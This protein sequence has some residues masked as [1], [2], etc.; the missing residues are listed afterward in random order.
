[1]TDT[2]W[3]WLGKVL[4]VNSNILRSLIYHRTTSYC[5]VEEG[6]VALASLSSP[7]SEEAL[8]F[9]FFLARFFALLDISLLPSDALRC[10]GGDPFPFFFVL[11]TS[12]HS[13]SSPLSESDS[14]FNAANL[15]VENV[16][17]L[18]MPALQVNLSVLC[19]IYT[20]IPCHVV[21]SFPG[22][23]GTRLAMWISSMA[24]HSLGTRPFA[25]GGGRGVWEHACIQVV[26]MEYNYAW[27][28]SDQL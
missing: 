17:P 22:R 2:L 14:I 25:R 4:Y 8:W 15:A 18:H 20:G 13:S 19:V 7:T 23:V 5:T 21:A 16:Q 9:L 1:M 3:H 12:C 24:R 27:V 11:H 10:S 26:L 28:I 6:S